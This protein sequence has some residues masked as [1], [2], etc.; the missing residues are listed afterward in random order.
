M[1]RVRRML[2]VQK[3]VDDDRIEMLER[4]IREASDTV[5]ESERKYEEVLL[6]L[7]VCCRTVLSDT[8]CSW[9]L[10][11][12]REGI[13]IYVIIQAIGPFLSKL[14]ACCVKLCSLHSL[15]YFPIE[16]NSRSQKTLLVSV[17]VYQIQQNR[18]C[19]EIFSSILSSHLT[20]K[21]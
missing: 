19:P 18:S 1:L 11:F 3:N 4:M 16:C 6:P 9:L 17:H 20:L 8:D 2:D 14:D 21:H 5:M 13:V 15:N 12:I 7:T 10:L